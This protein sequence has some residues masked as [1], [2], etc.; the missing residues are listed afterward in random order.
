MA[1]D[2]NEKFD[3]LDLVMNAL[4]DHE[5]KLDDISHRLESL[6]D[7]QLIDKSKVVRKEEQLIETPMAERIPLVIFR[8]W[9]EF[10]NTCSGARRATFEIENN[11]FHVY[12][13]I[14]GDI[15]RYSEK[16][17]N[18]LKII[19]EQSY[20]LIDKSCLT[21]IDSLQFLI[22]RRLKCGVNL[23]IKSSRIVSMEKQSLLEVV[24]DIDASAAKNFLSNEMDIPKKGIFEGKITY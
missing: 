23:A 12:A 8:K 21:S 6:F 4:R 5:K 7:G 13:M 1:S 17:P 11:F 20:F 14:N 24:Y 19:E 9:N 3:A 10:K 16:L 18:K 15:F 2:F 22:N